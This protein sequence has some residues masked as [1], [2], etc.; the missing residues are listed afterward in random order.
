M[1]VSPKT[2]RSDPALRLSSEARGPEWELVSFN[3]RFGLS[4]R[5]FKDVY[6]DFLVMVDPLDLQKKRVTPEV[7]SS[8]IWMRRRPSADKWPR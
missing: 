7:N 1:R 4:S 5:E 3:A 8:G 6:G 2:K